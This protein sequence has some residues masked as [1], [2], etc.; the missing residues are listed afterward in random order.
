MSGSN[1]LFYLDSAGGKQDGALHADILDNP[2]AEEACA[3]DAV[4]RGIHV[5]GMSEADALLSFGLPGTAGLLAAHRAGEASEPEATDDD[6]RN[7]FHPDL[8]KDAG[9]PPK[10]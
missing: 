8:L 6:L 4:L 3:L 7:M 10:P 1:E 5:Y 9:I 2:A